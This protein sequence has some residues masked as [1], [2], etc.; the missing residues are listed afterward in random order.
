MIMFSVWLVNCVRRDS[1]HS[2]RAREYRINT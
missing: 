1:H 2:E